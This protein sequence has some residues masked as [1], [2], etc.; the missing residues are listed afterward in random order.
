MYP[1]QLKI[2]E[3][4]LIKIYLRL[5]Q[6]RMVQIP[7]HVST[8]KITWQIKPIRKNMIFPPPDQKTN[9]RWLSLKP[10]FKFEMMPLNDKKTVYK[11]KF[12]F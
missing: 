9:E 8:Q 11:L 3:P 6:D 10:G 2:K 5:E 1:F 12:H 7:K 4:E